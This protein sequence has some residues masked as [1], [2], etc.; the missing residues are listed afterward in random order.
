MRVITGERREHVYSCDLLYVV[1]SVTWKTWAF[2]MGSAR[3]QEGHH[4]RKG[5]NPH[6]KGRRIR[7]NTPAIMMCT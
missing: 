2:Y 5:V 6:A 1:V 4:A 7:L 3:T